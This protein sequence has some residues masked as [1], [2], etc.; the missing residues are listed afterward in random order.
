MLL[1]S[2][3]SLPLFH[4]FAPLP[5]GVPKTKF[6]PASPSGDCFSPK[7]VSITALAAADAAHATAHELLE[8]DDEDELEL[9]DDGAGA[10]DEDELELEDDGAGAVAAG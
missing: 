1:F 10:D 5:P 6:A 2:V 3:S 8:D 4:D 7:P 9:E